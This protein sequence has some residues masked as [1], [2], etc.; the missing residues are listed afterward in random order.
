MIANRRLIAYSDWP[1]AT[2]RRRLEVSHFST[3]D[4]ENAC[5][6]ESDGVF[7]IACIRMHRYACT[8][9]QRCQRDEEESMVMHACI[10]K[11]VMMWAGLSTAV[12][13]NHAIRI[14]EKVRKSG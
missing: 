3:I 7:R 8:C 12:P 11:V 14:V 9:T 2:I 6:S 4:D 13:A 1:R 5:V 10:I